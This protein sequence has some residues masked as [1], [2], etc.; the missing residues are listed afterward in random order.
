MSRTVDEYMQLPYR[1]ILT[2]DR[3]QDGNEGWVAEV[4]ELPGCLSQG[5]TPEDA[6]AKIRDA[7][8]GWISVALEDGHTIPE[9][10]DDGYSGKFVI[11]VPSSL[12][13]DLARAAREEGVS[14]NQFA[15]GVLASAVSWRLPHRP[16]AGRGGARSKRRRSKRAG[17]RRSTPA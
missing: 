9:P 8:L 17:S 3:D 11:R 16:G 1:V 7:M 15:S 5:A 6:A 4:A 10:G 13:R 2:Y 12:H 14:L